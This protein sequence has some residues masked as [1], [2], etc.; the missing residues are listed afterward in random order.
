MVI[1]VRSSVNAYG[2]Q[3]HLFDLVFLRSIDALDNSAFK[4]NVADVGGETNKGVLFLFAIIVAA[5]K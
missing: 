5:V 1:S 2:L 3:R 4:V